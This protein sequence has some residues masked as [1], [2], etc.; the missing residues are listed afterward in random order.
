VGWHARPG[1]QDP[2]LKQGQ[3]V[4]PTT[5]DTQVASTHREPSAQLS[6]H[7]HPSVPISQTSH[8]AVV[9]LQLSPAVQV[10]SEQV[11]QDP[12]LQ[13]QSALPSGHS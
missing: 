5:Q 4:V 8:R 12:S 10:L 9:A 3:S 6:M 13:G 11:S 7:E 2:S 1:R